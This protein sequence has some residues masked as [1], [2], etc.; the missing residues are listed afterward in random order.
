VSWDGTDAS[1]APAPEGRYHW[2]V[3]ATDDLGRTSVADRTFTVDD[4]LG[5]LH[6]RRNARTISF[7]LARDATIRVTI[8]TLYGDILRTIAAG[9]RTTGPVTVHWK[10]RDGRG[11]RVPPGTYVVHVAANSPIGLSELRYVFNIR[12]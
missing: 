7:S 3:T 12:G 9:P 5:F 2:T 6:V 4:T 11:K 8:E 1:G 10:G